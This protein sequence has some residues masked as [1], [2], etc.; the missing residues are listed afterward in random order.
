METAETAEGN[1][2][3]QLD[4]ANLDAQNLSA[5]KSFL[6]NAQGFAATALT[7]ST[8]AASSHGSAV[9]V[10]SQLVQAIS[11]L[12]GFVSAAKTAYDECKAA[13]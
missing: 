9:T 5:L 10:Y 13:L 6:A 8:N 4:N 1:A 7:A 12:E 2:S 11:D 3:G